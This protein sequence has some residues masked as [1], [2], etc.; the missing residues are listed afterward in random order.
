MKRSTRK[1]IA[2]ETAEILKSGS[3]RVHG[4]DV[5]LRES[6][7]RSKAETRCYDPVALNEL[8]HSLKPAEATEANISVGN[9]TTLDGAQD[10]LQHSESVAALNF[11]SAKNPGGGFLGG[12]EAQEEAICRP[13][14]LYSSLETQMENYYEANRRGSNALYS[15]RTIYS[16]HV[17][18][19][20]DE[21][22]E[23]LEQPYELAFVTAPAPNRGALE[24]NS[25][26]LLSEVEPVFRRRIVSV[27][28]VMA[29]HGHRNVVLGAWGCGVFRNSARDVATWFHHALVEL[30]WQSHFD[31]VRF[32]VLDR[33]NDGTF[34]AFADQFASAPT[35]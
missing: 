17:Q 11:A 13:S 8:V 32:S 29:H 2:L 12:A 20:R 28:A 7:A 27:L 5:D 14:T 10:L 16:P 22:G 19:F 23:F 26:G 34:E 15:D 4:T 31:H 21:E 30:G 24:H 25:P 9:E 6:L 35:R 1:T 18:V 3:Y 33:R